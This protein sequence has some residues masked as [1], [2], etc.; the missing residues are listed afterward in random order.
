MTKAQDPHGFDNNN[1]FLFFSFET[2]YSASH[3]EVSGELKEKEK[4]RKG[5]EKRKKGKESKKEKRKKDLPH[6]YTI[7]EKRC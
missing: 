6:I 5:K 1:T 7:P 3:H 2:I 4:K